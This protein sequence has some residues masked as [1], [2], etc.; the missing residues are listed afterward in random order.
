MTDQRLV[1]L[2]RRVRLVRRRLFLQRLLDRIG[3]AMALAAA[4]F[5]LWRFVRLMFAPGLDSS[6]DLLVGCVALALAGVW[7]VVDAV[8]RTPPL[9]RVALAI[10]ERFQLRER[11]TT[12]LAIPP[13]RIA[14]EVGQAILDDATRRTVSIR[15]TSRFPIRPTWRLLGVPLA[16]AVVGLAMWLTRLAPDSD[17]PDSRADTAAVNPTTA[18]ALEQLKD[19]LAATR[20]PERTSDSTTRS[21]DVEEIQARLE[22]ILKKSMSTPEDL[23]ERLA[24]V[25]ALEENV[26]KQEQRQAEMLSELK[27]QLSK[28]DRARKDPPRDPD[29]PPDAKQDDDPVDSLRQALAEG[30]TATARDEIDRLSKRLKDKDIEP[31]ELDHLRG[32]L[33]QLHKDLKSIAE[34]HEQE[35]QERQTKLEQRLAE[36][37]RELDQQLAEGQIDPQEYE[38]QKKNIEQQGQ[39]DARQIEQQRQRLQQLQQSLE[40]CGQCLGENDRDGASAAL[41]EA[42]KQLDEMDRESQAH[43]ALQGELQQIRDAREALAEACDKPGGSR[44]KTGEDAEELTRRREGGSESSGR[45]GQG[46]QGSGRSRVG[47][48]R[49]PDGKPMDTDSADARQRSRF[50]PKGAK[51]QVG[52]AGQAERVIGKTSVTIQGEIQQ[53]AQEA[54]EAIETQRIPR[55]Y[56]DTTKGYF[57]N[58]GNQKLGSNPTKP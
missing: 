43:E 45:K 52:V 57:R 19:R 6:V 13:E 36:Q 46:G 56:K 37:R 15:V 22:Q 9:P 41:R 42:G 12:A 11:L 10:D 24:E 8:R 54:P 14:S 49:R 30:D 3:P 40:R 29:T 58:I 53:A 2:I 48:G 50:D 38:K 33:E 4:V 23:R 39:A 1:E 31:K 26:R 18:Q 47:V 20:Q 35:L 17:D 21:P 5:L 34:E 44:I 16:I 55:S 27:E 32:E 28:L 51:M 25:S 7:V